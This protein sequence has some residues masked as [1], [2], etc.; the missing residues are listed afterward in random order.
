MVDT[1]VAAGRWVLYRQNAALARRGARGIV[2]TT[3]APPLQERTTPCLPPAALAGA[4]PLP[5]SPLPIVCSPGQ[6]LQC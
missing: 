4:Y 3:R 6:R 5:V 2:F 1:P